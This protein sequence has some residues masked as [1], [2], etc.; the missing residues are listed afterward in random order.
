MN[1]V[2]YA[3]NKCDIET[4]LRGDDSINTMIPG[5]QSK[6]MPYKNINSTN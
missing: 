4:F 5:I 3:L 6:G 2:E 1:S